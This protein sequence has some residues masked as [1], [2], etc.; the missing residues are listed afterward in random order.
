MNKIINIMVLSSILTFFGCKSKE[1]KFLQEHKVILCCNSR[2]FPENRLTKEAIEFEKKQN[3]SFDKASS[4]YLNF[5]DK[6]KVKDDS[7][8]SKTILPSLIIDKYYVYSFK[9]IKMLKVAV[10]GIWVN[11]DTGEVINGKDK[12]WLY[13][14]DIL[15]KY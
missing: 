2:Y 3:I 11:A 15:K 12:I 5:T 4:I 8:K 10:F 13:E 9:N 7:I 1:E 14:D 6:K